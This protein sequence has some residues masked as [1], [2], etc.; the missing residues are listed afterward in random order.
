MGAIVKLVLTD[1]QLG[2]QEAVLTALQNR[3]YMHGN[4]PRLVTVQ[5]RVLFKTLQKSDCVVVSTSNNNNNK[6]KTLVPDKQQLLPRRRRRQQA[7]MNQL[8][9]MNMNSA[10][11]STNNKMQQ[12]QRRRSLNETAAASLTSMGQAVAKYALSKVM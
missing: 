2:I 11:V 12:Q 6:K 7:A 3:A 1:N 9:N 8:N 5:K 10:A 4:R